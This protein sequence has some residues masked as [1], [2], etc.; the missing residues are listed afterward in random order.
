[1]NSDPGRGKDPRGLDEALDQ[2]QSSWDG[3]ERAEPPDLLDQ[4]VLNAA[5]R[6]LAPARGTGRLRWIS[7]FATAGVAVV[8]LSLVWLQEPA[9][10]PPPKNFSAPPEQSSTEKSGSQSKLDSVN[11]DGMKKQ[12]ISPARQAATPAA[13]SV[14]EAE[15]MM[16]TSNRLRV[17]EIASEELDE[18]VQK[19]APIAP[20]DW[21]ELLLHLQEQGEHEELTRQL[22][23]FLARYPDYPLPEALQDWLP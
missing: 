2:L 13:A 3:Q 1:M 16:D 23:D 9:Q 21:L 19:E 14:S 7:G 5:R 12:E 18:S 22:Q 20:E 10:K 4:A 6:D 15:A 17:A 11:A 8:A